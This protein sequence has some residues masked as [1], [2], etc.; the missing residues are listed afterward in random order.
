MPTVTKRDLV[1]ELSNR[2]GLTQQ[3]VFS[4]VQGLLDTVTDKLAGG[5][6]VVLRNFGSFQVRETKAKIGRNPNEPGSDVPIP[7]RA[8]VKFKV[9]KELKERV[10]KLL[11][12]IQERTK[13]KR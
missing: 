4:V 5:E 8:V 7:P 6:E 12:S 1:I 10:A 3:Q 9:G 2:T 13:R 11:P